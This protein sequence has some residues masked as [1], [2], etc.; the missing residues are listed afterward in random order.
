MIEFSKLYKNWKI[1]RKIPLAALLWFFVFVFVLGLLSG[2]F[3]KQFTDTI[4]DKLIDYAV[5]FVLIP[6]AILSY[7]YSIFLISKMLKL[8]KLAPIL[9]DE[10]CEFQ[11][12]LNGEWLIMLI[13]FILWLPDSI[14]RLF[15]KFPSDL[16]IFSSFIIFGFYP[17]IRKYYNVLIRKPK[18]EIGD[19]ILYKTGFFAVFFMASIIGFTMIAATYGP[20]FA[21][22]FLLSLDANSTISILKFSIC[23]LGVS[24]FLGF[25]IA[26]RSIYGWE[27]P[28]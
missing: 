24:F 20:D 17:I 25:A 22:G 16:F 27:Y 13:Y 15:S 1:V 14:F 9:S 8:I 18:D 21:K 4:S 11:N 23:A 26:R 10:M 2:F 7:G 6:I 12:K 28:E 3:Q 5:Y 19:L